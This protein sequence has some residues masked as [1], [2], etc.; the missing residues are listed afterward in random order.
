MEL[1][2]RCVVSYQWNYLSI[3]QMCCLNVDDV[4]SWFNNKTVYIMC[5]SASYT[6]FGP[7]SFLK[8]ELCVDE[9]HPFLRLCSTFKCRNALDFDFIYKLYFT[10][11]KILIIFFFR[12]LALQSLDYCAR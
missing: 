9:L 8:A 5:F 6:V 12:E 7:A 4:I 11:V 10:F 2:K 1:S 3:N